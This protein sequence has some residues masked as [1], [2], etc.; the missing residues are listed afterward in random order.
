MLFET[1]NTELTIEQAS[2]LASKITDNRVTSDTIRYLIRIGRLSPL[3]QSPSGDILDRQEVEHYFLERPRKLEQSFKKSLDPDL[4]WRL[5]FSEYQESET[6]KH[7]HR[8]HPYKGKFIPQLVEYF[9]DTNTDEFKTDVFFHPGDVILDPFC[10]SGTTL[11]QC[12]EL[13]IHALGVDTSE[14]NSLISNCKLTAVDVD[15]LR[16]EA[17]KIRTCLELDATTITARLLEKELKS[18][19]NEFNKVHFPSP[20]F[21]QSVTD[22]TI[23]EKQFGHRQAKRLQVK[24]ERLCEKHKL[25]FNVD[26]GGNNFLERWFVSTIQHE[27]SLIHKRIEEIESTSTRNLMSLVLTRTVRSVRAT[28]HFDLTTLTEPIQEPYYCPKHFKICTPKITLYG[29]WNRYLMDT[30]RRLTEFQSRRT[31]THQECVVGDSKNVDFLG[32]IQNQ[33]LR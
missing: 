14:F 29:W 33:H 21:R 6:T 22:G 2:T 7:V 19:V 23:D 26:L 27:I 13:G 18:L 8:I 11:V 31:N 9:V 32:R 30:V 12:N 3:R 1:S 5:S 16:I 20:R 28:K 24:F 10:G 4:N 15:Q 17:V 25:N